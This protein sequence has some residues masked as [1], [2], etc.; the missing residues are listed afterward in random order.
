MP[1]GVLRL[2]WQPPPFYIFSNGG[3]QGAAPQG[4]RGPRKTA[5]AT[6]SSPAGLLAVT[7]PSCGGFAPE[8]AC[9]KAPFLRMVL[10]E[11]G[12]CGRLLVRPLGAAQCKAARNLPRVHTFANGAIARWPRDGFP[13]RK[14]RFKDK[15]P[16]FKTLLGD[17]LPGP[18]W[19]WQA[20]AKLGQGTRL[21]VV[22]L[23]LQLPVTH[24]SFTASSTN[25]PRFTT[26]SWSLIQRSRDFSADD[27]F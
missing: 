12:F 27:R 6:R 13:I 2:G 15:G 20:P 8:M 22:P 19:A 14:V 26:R 24:L 1:A 21:P 17:F 16:R 7:L 18:K 23:E 3:A 4:P 25:S 10:C 11:T 9:S 5:A